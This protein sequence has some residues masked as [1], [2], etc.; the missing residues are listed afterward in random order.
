VTVLTS[1]GRC[2]EPGHRSYSLDRTWDECQFK[3]HAR[4]SGLIVPRYDAKVAV[5]SAVDRLIKAVYTGEDMTPDGVLAQAAEELGAPKPRDRDIEKTVR[6]FDLWERRVR[7]AWDAVGVYAVEW[8]LHFEVDGIPYH[9]HLDT[10]LADGTVIDVKTS[11]KRLDTS[12]LGRAE[13]DP[14][15]TTYAA[16]LW[17]VFGTIPPR[18]ILDG[19]IDANEPDD[20][21]PVKA[22]KEKPWWD[23]QVATRTEEQLRSF[24]DD[25]RRREFSRRVARSAGIYQT[26][27]RSHPWACRGCEAVSICPAFKG[28]DGIAEGSIHFGNEAA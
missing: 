25:V 6:L 17:L 14:Q 21:Q 2:A 20:V 8:E 23:R 16:A 10:A 1:V 5:G 13:Y 9:V 18:V 26:N 11:E 27:G 3:G 15:L 7:P 28:W 12:G 19:L 4:E 22:K 24:L